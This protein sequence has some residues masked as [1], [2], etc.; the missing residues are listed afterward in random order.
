LNSTIQNAVK[1]MKNSDKPVTAIVSASALFS[2][3]ITLTKLD[4]T[5]MEQCH[6]MML[7][8][9][10]IFLNKLL[11]SKALIARQGAQFINDDCVSLTG[12]CL[13]YN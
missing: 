11:E 8:R 12:F 9:G 3:F 5:P 6:N 13:E 4:E 1:I 2:R 10:K 7:Q